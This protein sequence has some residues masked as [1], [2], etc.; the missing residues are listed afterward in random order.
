[1]LSGRDS[2]VL[3]RLGKGGGALVECLGGSGGGASDEEVRVWPEEVGVA[4]AG[5]GCESGG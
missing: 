1:M 3:F 2:L 5:M 4:G